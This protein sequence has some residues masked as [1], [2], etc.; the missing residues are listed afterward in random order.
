MVRQMSKS[1]DV[2]AL[3]PGT[4]EGESIRYCPKCGRDLEVCKRYTYDYLKCKCESLFTRDHDSDEIL[5]ITPYEVEKETNRLRRNIYQFYDFRTG[6]DLVARRTYNEWLEMYEFFD[7]RDG[8]L[9]RR[10]LQ[11]MEYKA[12]GEVWLKKPP[13][14][15][16]G[17][18]EEK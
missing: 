14:R 17:K 12:K 15:W 9:V 18:V 11:K 2:T 13:R 7:P 4:A 16:R 5:Y 1:D 6:T 10:D 8:K 3:A